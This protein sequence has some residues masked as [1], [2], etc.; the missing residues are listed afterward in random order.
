[1]EKT[2]ANPGVSQPSHNI[3][4]MLVIVLDNILVSQRQLTMLLK[5]ATGR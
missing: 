3:L 1:M 5:L 2:F 4:E